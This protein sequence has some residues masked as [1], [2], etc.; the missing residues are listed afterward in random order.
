MV[1]DPAATP[2]TV[3]ARLS[4]SP[5]IEVAPHTV[6]PHTVATFILRKLHVSN[7][8]MLDVLT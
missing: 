8:T 6:A 5:K 1:S 2:L 4:L 7:H 3:A